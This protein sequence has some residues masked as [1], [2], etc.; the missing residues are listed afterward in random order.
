MAGWTSA[1]GSLRE[2]LVQRRDEG[3][4]IPEDLFRRIEQLDPEEDAWNTAVIDPLYDELMGLQPD[5]DLLAREPS[6]LNSIRAARPDGPRNFQWNPSQEELLDRLHGAWTGRSVGCALG[7]PVEGMGMSRRD[8]KLV[9]RRRIKRYLQLRNDW[10]LR[11]YF[12]GRDVEGMPCEDTETGKGLGPQEATREQIAYMPADDDIHYS[13]VGLGVLEKHSPDFGWSDVA[14]YWS[15]HIPF[16][17]ICT[18]E[19]QAILNFWNHSVRWKGGGMDATPEFTRRHRNPYREWIGAQIRSD[20]WAWACAG[21]PEKAA[22]LA[23]RDACWTHERNGIYGEMMFAAIQAAAFVERDPRKLVEIGL[24]EIPSE[25]RLALATRE[26]LQW[27]EQCDTWED[28]M[29]RL[30]KA[31]AGMDP[32][33][34]INNALICV[35]SLFYGKTNPEESTEISVMCGLD[36]DCNGATVGSIVGAAAGRKAFGEHLAGQLNDTIRPNMIGFQQT[37]MID[38]ARR[39]ATVWKRVRDPQ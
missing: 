28:C 6:D 11:D 35:L 22:E 32:V 30:D 15:D 3:C 17:A 9:G 19:A 2:E 7:K 5:A 25:C 38:L 12:S 31:Y 36:T 14:L 37:K 4:E 34:T 29:D 10:P 20:G 21:N 39:T 33:H 24:S 26:C 18:A 13:L 1:L 23:Y 16:G 8:G 27:L